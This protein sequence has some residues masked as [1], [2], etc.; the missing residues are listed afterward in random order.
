[1]RAVLY[2][3]FA[4]LLILLLAGCA[5][6]V[7]YRYYTL[8]PVAERESAGLSDSIGIMPVSIP[9]WLDR[10]NMGY[11]DDAFQLHQLSLDRWGEPLAEAITRV[12]TQNLQHK[13]PQADVFHG[14][15]LRSQRPKIKIQVDIQ[16]LMLKGQQ[17]ELEV[18]WRINGER[19]VNRYQVAINEQPSAVELARAISQQLEQFTDD[20][21]KGL[22]GA[23]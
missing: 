22:K 5:N 13:N 12:L 20:L 3:P 16:N 7:P 8:Q 17:L 2:R 4:L 19:R 18:S 23:S 10:S 9:S 14:P 15:W 21:Q 11:I 6:S 1:M